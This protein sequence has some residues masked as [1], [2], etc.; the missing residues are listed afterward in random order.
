MYFQIKEII[1]WSKTSSPPPR[2]VKFETGMVNVI[3]GASRTGKSAIIPI[4]DYCLG[5]D[6]CTIPVNT[7]RD[8]CG[9]FGI[10]IQTIVGEKLLAR[11]EP[12]VQKSTGDMFVLE[13]QTVAIPNAIQE[14]NTNAESVKRMLDELAGLTAL[15]FDVEGASNW[16]KGRPSFRDLGAFNYQPQNIVANPD[17][18]FYKADTY[19]HR[20]KLK[21]IFP[22]ILGAITPQLLA[23]QHE[24]S[25]LR[26]D[27]RKKQGELANVKDVSQRWVAEIQARVSEAK[28]LG[29]IK[30]LNLT[31]A[32]REHLIEILS[33]IVTSSDYEI[34]VTAETIN[35]AVDELIQLQKEESAVSLELS[36]L[37]KRQTE[38]AT[39]RESTVLYQGAL[40]VQRDRLQ[41]SEW[42]GKT[43]DKEHDCPL[44]GNGLDQPAKQLEMLYH[45]LKE[46]ETTAGEFYAIPASFDREYERVRAEIQTNT[47]K[48]KGIRIRLNSLQQTSAQAKQRQY[49]SLRVSRF[50]GNL[51]QSLQTYV[52]IGINSELDKEVDELR[53]RVSEI[54]A[55]IS[56][57]KY[58]ARTTRALEIVSLNAERLIPNLDS[59]R[60][61]DPISLSINDLTIK[62]G[63]VNRDDYL[64]EIGSGSNWLAYHVAVTL[65]LHQFFLSQKHSPVPSFIVYDQPS[66]VYF[67]KPVAVRPSELEL[68]PKF[69]DEDIEAVHKVFNVISGVAG[70][71]KKS[72]QVIV[73]DHAPETVWG[74][75]ENIHL[76]EEWRGGRK[77]IP[78]EWIE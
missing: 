15:D 75:V 47:E 48:L 26:K 61:D 53:Q 2:R 55:E 37:R 54:E 62:V 38:M 24:L 59:E 73:L 70:K 30:D 29:L 5:A 43:H 65:G 32:T 4:I 67:P 33:Q 20:E 63:G 8:A 3:S 78:L 10:L 16:F 58:R 14:K 40:Q 22:Y 21:T 60:P 66:Q 68:D 17:V 23:R 69:K 28:E 36:S 11:R 25:Q 45:S 6:K 42:L 52:K 44:C 72:F 56:V 27:L 19:E 9:W 7:I 77:L 64:W 51:E 12:G 18:F 31:A 35:D 39:L 49:N 41:I 13:A 50:I 71:S 76:V 34:K 1:L 74:D 57:D 46:I